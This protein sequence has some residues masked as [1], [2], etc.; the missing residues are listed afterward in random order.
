M[1]LTK[2]LLGRQRLAHTRPALARLGFPFGAG[3]Q[4]RQQLV[5]Q[6][7]ILKVNLKQLPKNQAVLLAADHDGFKGGAQIGFFADA[8]RQCSFFGQHDAAA[9]DLDASTPQG[10]AKTGDVVG[11][12][13]A[14]RVT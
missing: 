14:A 6:F 8:H 2:A 10:P 3:Q 7:G 11:Q 9:V 13:A 5:G 4:L 1:S 12:L